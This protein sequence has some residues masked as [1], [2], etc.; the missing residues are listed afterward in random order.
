NAE[1]LAANGSDKGCVKVDMAKWKPAVDELA[2]TV[3][4]IKGRGDKALAEKT[5]KGIV[6]DDK[7]FAKLREVITERWLRTP[8]ASF[9]YAIR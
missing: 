1:E 5:R 2:K 6:D 7:E 4:G 8:K 9:V 3:L